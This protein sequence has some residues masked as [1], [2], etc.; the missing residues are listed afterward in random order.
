MSEIDQ[1]LDIFNAEVGYLEKSKEAYRQDPTVLYDKTRG[2]GSDN[3]TKYAKEMDELNVYNGIKQGY[4]WC[5]IFIDW[6]FV[7]AL[8]LDRTRELLIGFSAGCQQDWNWLKSAGRIVSNPQ[9][10]D[11]IFFRNLSH[12]G[13]IEKVENGKI[14]TIEGN[15][16]NKAELITNGGT[17]A[18]KNI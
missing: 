12:I 10:G 9:R 6:C 16:S 11:L 17:V 4:A 1:L 3:Y 13:I 8:G 5:D 18:K 15:T 14:Y 2:A 7:Q